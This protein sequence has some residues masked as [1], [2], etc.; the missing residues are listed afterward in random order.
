MI[1]DDEYTNTAVFRSGEK[2]CSGNSTRLDGRRRS[3]RS[4][5]LAVVVGVTSIC[6]ATRGGVTT[7]FSKAETNYGGCLWLQLNKEAEL[8]NFVNQ[9]QKRVDSYSNDAF[10]TISFLK[11]FPA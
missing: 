10:F 5:F 8:I 6:F 2:I 7:V 4:I 11:Y 3:D 1:V 9:L